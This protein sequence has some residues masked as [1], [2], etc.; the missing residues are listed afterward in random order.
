MPRNPLTYRRHAAAALLCC[1]AALPALAESQPYPAKPIHLIVPFSPGGAVDLVARALGIE[2]TGLTKQPVVVENRTGAGGN[3]AGA[4]VAKSEPDGYTLLL[5]STGMSVNGSL[6]ANL[7]YSPEHDL[8]PIALVGSVPE[9]LLLHPSVPAKTFDELAALARAKPES[10]NFAHG[11]GGTT[12]HL[13]AV[14]LIQKLDANVQLVPY[15]G[16]GPAMTDLLGGQTQLLF[17]NLLNAIPSLRA[18][19]LKALAI[20]SSQRSKQ[21]PDVPTFAEMGVPDFSIEVWWGVMGPAGMPAPVVTRINELVN[22][23]LV[24]DQFV[25]RLD[26]VGAQAKPGTPAQFSDFFNKEVVRWGAVVRA[27]N[28]TP[29]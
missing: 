7:N 5:A 10:L 13:A 23:A 8:L 27:G 15:K 24:A 25:A 14:L 20:A 22:T 16:G 12:E 18:G 28:I 29:D 1:L 26:S 17:T 4:F 6:Y 21:L 9:V 11:G 19:T 3:I 2:I